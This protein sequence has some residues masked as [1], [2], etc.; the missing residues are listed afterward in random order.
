MS[1][2]SLSVVEAQEY[3]THKATIKEHDES[4]FKWALAVAEIKSKKL[5]RKDY[6][7]F[8]AFC[9][10]ELQWTRQYVTKLLG[11][12]IIVSQL[13]PL[14]AAKVK[15]I[16][17]ADAL[18]CVPP[19]YRARV[20]QAVAPVHGQVA[21]AAAIK[22]ES[23]V[24]IPPKT[25]AKAPIF[26][27][28][29]PLSKA[30]PKPPIPALILAR[31]RL[32][33]G[34][35]F[36]LPEN[37]LDLWHRKQEVQDMVTLLNNI[38]AT[39]KRA[40]ESKDPLYAEVSESDVLSHIDMVKAALKGGKLYAVC[41]SCKG[42][43]MLVEGCTDCRCRGLVSEFFWTNLVPIETKKMREENNILNNSST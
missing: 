43:A 11:A 26:A 8:E 17:A 34:T 40:K 21:T 19:V 22:M 35:G 4:V 20:V 30:A 2:D 27:P 3:E 29:P 5:F 33:D 14:Q 25:P 9:E 1:N 15:S 28:P 13:P 24:Y 18:K 39:V 38:R 6:A 31:E 16:A 42:K 12:A 32:L 7:T 23:V 37:V 36:I 10:Q 41:P